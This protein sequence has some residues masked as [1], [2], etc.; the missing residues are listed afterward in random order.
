M[1]ALATRVESDLEIR[2]RDLS[3]T[4]TDGPTVSIAMEISDGLTFEKLQKLSE[5]FKTRT[6]N[7]IAEARDEGGCPT[8]GSD[9]QSWTGLDI[10]DATLPD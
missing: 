1:P 2:L 5:F 9:L 7:V 3:V 6:I 4:S 10:Q 8:C